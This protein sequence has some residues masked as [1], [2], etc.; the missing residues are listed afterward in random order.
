[1]NRKLLLVIII[2]VL[3]RIA[4]INSPMVDAFGSMRQTYTAGFTKYM[5][6]NGV[7][8]SNVMQPVSIVQDR[9]SLEIP[10]YNLSTVFLS[11]I[12]GEHDWVYR[13]TSLLYWII[14]AFY[15]AYCLRRI[16]TEKET[17]YILWVYTLLPLSIFIGH[18]Y[19]PEVLSIFL[20][21][22]V[23]FNAYLYL[24]E[25]KPVDLVIS[26]VAL[27]FALLVRASHFHLII[28]LLLLG[29]SQYGFR[30]F[31]KPWIYAYLIPLV[32]V[33]AWCTSGNDLASSQSMNQYLGAFAFRFTPVYLGMILFNRLG[34]LTLSPV[35][36]PLLV[37]A[38]AS[39]RN[40][41]NKALDFA[42]FYGALAF[43]LI[44][45]GGNFIHPHYQS[46][47]I[48]PFA[49][50]IGRFLCQMSENNLADSWYGWWRAI[51]KAVLAFVLS[52]YIFF[53][54]FVFYIFFSSPWDVVQLKSQIA[55][56][57][58]KLIFII[59]VVSQ[60]VLV[61]GILSLM[62][63]EILKRGFNTPR[64]AVI[65]IALIFI[66]G[67]IVIHPMYQT[68][69]DYID[70][71]ESISANL[72]KDAKV[73]FVG[74]KDNADPFI[75]YSS[76]TI[77]WDYNTKIFLWRKWDKLIEIRDSGAEYLT[78]MRNNR[79][80]QPEHKLFPEINSY[81]SQ[82]DVVFEDEHITIYNL[83]SIPVAL[84]P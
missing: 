61:L 34:G 8:V 53:D 32:A 21:M 48:L 15:L 24:K 55:S 71:A 57:D 54:C 47:V 11:K 45:A 51:P 25:G 77:A 19:H 50:L 10:I 30:L 36:L 62:K 26:V 83:S 37:M 2:G 63:T 59:F 29:L 41:T 35:G 40:R 1:M 22:A 76:Q 28:V 75:F 27:L 73:A 81:L 9:H 82:L 12:F 39:A 18:Y 56:L 13:L 58:L 16:Y 79:F 14:G 70:A 17:S 20:S 7:T 78:V 3:L 44:V 6:N 80:V 72:D 23:V 38:V 67:L 84:V 33:V 49:I 69:M 68:E 43:L 65:F 42:W 31:L 46:A 4:F 66:T 52:L 74:R 5:I 60:I 64:P